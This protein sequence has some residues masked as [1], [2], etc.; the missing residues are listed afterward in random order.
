MALT[1]A[2]SILATI[3]G[4]DL[5]S[6]VLEK[7][8]GSFGK[9]SEEASLAAAKAEEAAAQMDA[10]LLS[11]ASG[12]DA[13]TIAYAQLSAAR[14]ADDEATRAQAKAEQELL[15]A[16]DEAANAAFGD[17]AAQTRLLEANK[18]LTKAQKDAAATAKEL[19]IAETN[20]S[21]VAA[22]ASGAN[23]RAA[24]EQVIAA[25]EQ[26]AASER[27]SAAS[28]ESSMKAKNAAG[29]GA[30][31]V[32]AIGY[33]SIKAAV[34]FQT[35][36]TRLVTTAGESKSSL[37]MVQQ[38]IIALSNQT[39]ISADDLSKA[40]Y[41]VESGGY[42]G[43]EGLDVLKAAEEGAATEG[44]NFTDVA[45]AVSNIL[46]AY[47]MHGKDA[48]KMTSELTAAVSVGKANFQTMST[49]MGTVLPVAASMHLKFNDVAGTLAEMTAQGIPAL[50]ASQNLANAMRSLEKPSATMQKEFKAV[51]ITT[52]ELS[53]HLASQGL[54]GTLQWLSQ[55][56][57]ANA[58]R[59]HQTYGGALGALMGTAAGLNVALTTTGKHANDTARNIATIGKASADAN[60]HVLGFADLQKTAAFQ[61]NRA[62]QAIVNVGIA[63]GSAL[64]PAVTNVAQA[65]SRVVIP[66]ATWIQKHQQLV[67]TVFKV[68][69]A[70]LAVI[71][72]VKTFTVVVEILRG[73]LMLL[74]E[75]PWVAAITVLI[76]LVIYA[77]THFKAFRQVVNEVARF[78]GSVFKAA[79]EAAGKVIKAFTPVWE[80][81]VKGIKAV[82]KWFDDNVLSWLKAR[83][84][85]FSSWW[86]AHS[87]QILQ[88]WN[89]IWNLIKLA[90]KI[91]WD[92]FMKPTLSVISSVWHTVWGAIKDSIKM[93]WDFISGIVTTAIHIVLNTISVVLDVITGK[94]GKAWQ[95]VKKLVSQGLHD[96]I[97][98]IGN[99]VSDFG[100]LLFDAGKNVINGLING[101]KSMI[102]G[103]GNIMG[104]IGHTIRSFLPFSPAKRG[105]LSG[106]GSPDI[107]GRKIGSMV[108][109]GLIN[110]VPE[111]ETA[112]RKAV[113]TASRALKTGQG[114]NVG[115]GGMFSVGGG[116]SFAGTAGAPGVHIRIDVHDNT[117]MNDRD[118][119]FLVQK[120]ERRLA[121]LTLP[122]GGY[123]SKF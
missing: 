66:I 119:D 19:S 76:G 48:A 1:E 7:V 41:I 22:A 12:A 37:K 63:I 6:N 10:A 72:V 71:G 114:F 43:K 99:T 18:A 107:A 38:G 36:T 121:T 78:L 92:G 123:R 21:R 49:A 68:V 101:I 23:L 2:I 50:R 105:P 47:S 59:L 33:E 90:T 61:L 45:N 39:G 118:V 74:A 34:S 79:W 95:D 113:D 117:I 98:T 58:G 8:G 77:Y 32:A 70:I 17:T 111:I 96:V 120:I 69:G 115:L 46:T 73:A 82:V 80:A 94:W 112:T 26:A 109:S 11:T 40:M 3:K 52:A 100:T 16:Q 29:M 60:G 44:A 55:E 91:W 86:H 56:A 110:S 27:A 35:L 30:L 24:R 20:M 15:I 28:A 65:I 62:K 84:S 85:E 53:Q 31:A 108:A 116:L 106:S 122:S 14:R 13:S 4:V 93:T 97:S 89:V 87:Q 81:M 57:A 54:G 83:M 103:L 75:N 5:V 67:T 9:M 64:L 25:D 104:S 88:V 42:H 51:G 102:G